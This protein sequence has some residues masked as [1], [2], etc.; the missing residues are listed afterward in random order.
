MSWHVLIVEDEEDIREGLAS[1][2]SARGYR[3]MTASNGNEALDLVR[4]RG[5]RPS[6]VVLDLAMP[7]MDGEEF[8][9]SQAGDPML[10]S[11]P[12][13]VLTAQPRPLDFASVKAVFAK[14]LD[15]PS[16]LS[17]LRRVCS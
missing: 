13:V 6:V 11:V 5:L 8:L 3:T 10:A 4:R 15:L 9:A 14:P 2:L 7:V 1:V 17:T 16:L 12:V